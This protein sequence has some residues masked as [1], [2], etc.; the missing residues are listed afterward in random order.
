MRSYS[1]NINAFEIKFFN[2]AGTEDLFGKQIGDFRI[3]LNF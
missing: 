2:D 1:L 3:N